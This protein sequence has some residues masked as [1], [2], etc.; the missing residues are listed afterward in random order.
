[1]E[2]RLTATLSII[3]LATC[4]FAGSAHAQTVPAGS[5]TLGG[6]ETFKAGPGCGK[7]TDLLNAT[8][9]LAANGAWSAHTLDA[10]YSGTATPADSKGRKWN[11]AFNGPSFAGFRGVL[12]DW[13]TTLCDYYEVTIDTLDVPKFTLKVNKLGNE[14]TV[15]LKAKATGHTDLGNGKGTYNTKLA[16]AWT[17]TSP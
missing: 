16:G 2:N 4:V 8:L 7:E 12:E 1:M 3:A 15:K 9:S 13:A 14:A 6:N 11:F 10:D 17:L 5:G